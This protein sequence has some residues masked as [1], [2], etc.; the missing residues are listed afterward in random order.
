MFEKLLLKAG[1]LMKYRHAMGPSWAPISGNL[2]CELTTPNI[3]CSG[4]RLS[5]NRQNVDTMELS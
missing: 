2:G 5:I 3:A 1:D 4:S